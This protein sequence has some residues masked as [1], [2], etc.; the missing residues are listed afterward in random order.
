MTNLTKATFAAG[1]FWGVEAAFR[2]I[3][4]VVRTTVGY[5]GGRT[6]EPSYEQ[7][8]S[9]TTGH[10]ES[11]EVWSWQGRGLAARAVSR[12][13]DRFG[14]QHP[15]NAEDRVVEARGQVF[16]Q[17]LSQQ[18]R[19]SQVADEHQVT[20]RQLALQRVVVT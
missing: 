2:E 12:I 3:E 18:L 17:S 19:S 9:D 1:C 16:G 6:S 13:Q 11:V 15:Q 14:R 4:G 7:V 8:C 5:T 20:L 10:A